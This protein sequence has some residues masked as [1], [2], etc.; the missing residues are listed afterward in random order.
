MD[1]NW[2]PNRLPIGAMVTNPTWTYVADEPTPGR[3]VNERLI[4]GGQMFIIL[5]GYVSVFRRHY[6]PALNRGK[7]VWLVGRTGKGKGAPDWT[8][9]FSTI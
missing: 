1:I 5:D 6:T 3:G 4:S 9:L 2:V 8:K 7:L